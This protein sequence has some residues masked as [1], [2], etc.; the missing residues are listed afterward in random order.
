MTD[1]MPAA[2]VA[3]PRMLGRV[4]T[5]LGSESTQDEFYFWADDRRLVEA[6]QIVRLTMP[7]PAEDPRVKKMKKQE[8]TVIAIVEAAK[9][10]SEA[11]TIGDDH[12]RYGGIGEQEPLL[13]P[14]GFGYAHCRVVALEPTIFVPVT[15]GLPVYLAT[16]DEAGRGYSYPD[17]DQNGT[18]LLVG[19]LQNGGS[20][21]SGAAK[22]DTRFILG[23][24]GGHVNVTGVAG[25]GTK[26][27][28]L[29]VLI[30]M[31]IL[32]ARTVTLSGPTRPLYITPIVFNVKGNDLMWLNQPN[33]AF[34]AQDQQWQAYRDNWGDDLFAA[35]A[36]PFTE[37]AFFSYPNVNGVARPGLPP[38]VSLY[39]WGLKD[40]LE[41][42]VEKYLLSGEARASELLAGVLTDA[43]DY[44]ADR[45]LTTLS[46]R[47]L[48][49]ANEAGVTNFRQLVDWIAAGAAKPEPDA[50]PHY[51]AARQ[52]D[53]AT[54][55]AAARR[56]NNILAEAKGVL[57]E[58]ATSGNPPEIV[59][60]GTCDPI[61]IDIA[62]LDGGIQRF[63]V[64]AI[65]ERVKRHREQ[66]A[67][68]P[69]RYLIVLDE[70]NR[71]AP[72]GGTDDV[73]KLF[74]H[75]A[76][77]LR[78]QGILL[79]GAQQKASS[80]STIVWENAATKVLGRT[81]AVELSA[82]MWRQALPSATRT[83]AANLQMAEKILIQEGLFAYPMLALIPLTPWA[84]K[85]SE[86]GDPQ[87]AKPEKEIEAA[88]FLSMGA[89][90]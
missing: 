66:N 18:G 43:F 51:L 80:V 72:K 22:L 55:K 59:R 34:N 78:S 23:E 6:T 77:Q 3:D 85:R 35:F 70:L 52:H 2:P 47:S 31:L 30:K 7:L 50:E 36:T 12:G 56:L 81:G 58:D 42:G 67:E 48:N 65:I 37:T 54:I 62:E 82:D 33:A 8:L 86:V 53:R 64:A 75:V 15:E 68:R 60:K 10:Q 16:A 69:Q 44:V 38:G 9:R 40:V 88:E 63:I 28:F 20:E 83:R 24:N 5:P 13:P 61:I 39:S 14:A 57:R 21:V 87:S 17:M 84:T 90:A 26:T 11:K 89:G 71:F 41:W 45:S 19:L 74:E 27:S 29:L 1:E 32:H 76:A 46:G 4:S 73:S 25:V 49:T 79:F